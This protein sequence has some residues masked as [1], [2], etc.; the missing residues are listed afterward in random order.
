M[1]TPPN[2]ALCRTQSTINPAKRTRVP[3]HSLM[4]W[5]RINLGTRDFLTHHAC[6]MLRINADSREHDQ[7]TD[8]Q[9]LRMNYCV[10]LS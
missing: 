9:S 5:R 4:R 6:H 3:R 2:Q 7:V 8:S 1:P 10:Q